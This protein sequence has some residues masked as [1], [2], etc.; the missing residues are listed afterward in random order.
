MFY[1]RDVSCNV[2]VNIYQWAYINLIFSQPSTAINY[3][4]PSTNDTFFV[5]YHHVDNITV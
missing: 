1:S 4:K 2:A 3:T 5:A